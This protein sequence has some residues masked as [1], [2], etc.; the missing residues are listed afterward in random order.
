ML[1]ALLAIPGCNPSVPDT[2]T[3]EDDVEPILFANCVRCHRDPPQN[4]AP[5][6]LDTFEAARD[7]SGGIVTRVKLDRDD[8]RFMP[9]NT[10]LVL[11]DR[12]IE[13]I[14]NWRAT[15]SQAGPRSLVGTSKPKVIASVDGSS[16]RDAVIVGYEL[17]RP[18]G[19]E[20]YGSVHVI[21]ED[22]GASF[23]L[24]EGLASGSGEVVWELDD[25]VGGAYEIVFEL[26]NGIDI[27]TVSAGVLTVPSPQ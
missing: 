6:R 2:P 22:T 19:G 1:W 16:Y 17:A 10:E 12:Q 26:D 21:D 5:I 8:P 14:E 25:Y 11:S 24:A 27:F 7:N 4:G 13:I 18:D 20:V 15:G 9:P 23:V 3:F